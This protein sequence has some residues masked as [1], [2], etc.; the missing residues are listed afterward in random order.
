MET[1]ADGD[2]FFET[3][4]FYKNGIKHLQTQDQNRDGTADV[5][6]YFNAKEEKQRV[7]SDTTLNGKT[8][9]WQF[10]RNDQIVRLEK[11]EDG[12][13]NIDLKVFLQKRFQGKIGQR[14]GS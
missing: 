9:T 2:G 10:Y 5:K 7:E 8:D 1:D 13:R 14:H 4:C 11:D 12:N 6:I 3:V